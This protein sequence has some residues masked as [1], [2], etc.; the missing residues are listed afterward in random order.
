MFPPS[1]PPAW[2]KKDWAFPPKL[3]GVVKP[4]EEQQPVM[5]FA[6][7]SYKSRVK[8]LFSGD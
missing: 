2:M 4:K 5:I 6:S 7:S 3:S 8:N 1:V